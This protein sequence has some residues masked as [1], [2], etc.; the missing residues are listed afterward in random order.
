[1]TR[2]REGYLNLNT[3]DIAIIAVMGALG[4]LLA[5]L[6]TYLGTI[7][8]QIAFDLSHLA[9]FMVSIFRGPA[10]GAIVGAIISIEPIYRFGITGWL[11]PVVGV[12]GFLPGKAMTG[13]FSGLLTRKTRPFLAVTIGYIPESVYTYLVLKY[14]TMLLIPNVAHFFSDAVIFTILIKAWIEIILMGVFMEIISRNQA[15][16]QW[17]S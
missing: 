6:T 3:K 4:N 2:R 13:F 7:H 17:L 12:I 1:M 10:M 8:P 11:G 16:K 14:L 5:T 9:T 15:V